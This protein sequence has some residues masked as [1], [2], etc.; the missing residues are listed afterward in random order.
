MQGRRG[1]KTLTKTTV[2]ASGEHLNYERGVSGISFSI[3][4]LYLE[5]CNYVVMS[6]DK[7][8]RNLPKN[9]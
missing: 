1:G 8:M 3:S 9:D 6:Q 2:E 5:L 7:Q 4:Q